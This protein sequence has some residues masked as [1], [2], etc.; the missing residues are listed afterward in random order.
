M[1]FSVPADIQ[2]K[3]DELDA[4]IESE[5]NKWQRVVKEAGIKAE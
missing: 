2:R 4:F 3:L 1:D 5:M